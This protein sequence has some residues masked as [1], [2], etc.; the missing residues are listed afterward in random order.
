MTS[1]ELN[2]WRR[3]NLEDTGDPGEGIDEAIEEAEER[4]ME[5]EIERGQE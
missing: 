4:E 3:V 1:R 2:Y 5:A